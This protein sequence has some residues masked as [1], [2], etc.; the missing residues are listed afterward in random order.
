MKL[1]CEDLRPK[2]KLSGRSDEPWAVGVYSRRDRHVPVVP[3]L[4]S[5][6][7]NKPLFI[8]QPHLSRITMSFINQDDPFLLA[9]R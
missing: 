3:L 8:L 9:Q 5:I 6:A 4:I 1:N 7:A 2:N